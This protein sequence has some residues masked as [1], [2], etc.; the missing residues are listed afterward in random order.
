MNVERQRHAEERGRI[1]QA[2]KEEYGRGAVTV[3]TLLGALDAL[4]YPM[5]PE[6]LQF[7][8]TYLCDQGYIGVTRAC[9]LPG[10]RRDRPNGVLP[11]SIVTARILPL[12]IQLIDGMAP[13]DA[14]VRF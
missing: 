9:E 6:S 4:G 5:L 14:G 1:L 11:D 8:L 10:W 7:S 3:S 13:E 2:L 12:G